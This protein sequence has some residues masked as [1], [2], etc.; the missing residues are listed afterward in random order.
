VLVTSSEVDAPDSVD[1]ENLLARL[2]ESNPELLARILVED[3]GTWR[4]SDE[5]KP[6]DLEAAKSIRK[7]VEHWLVGLGDLGPLLFPTREGSLPTSGA[8]FDG[9]MLTA[10]WHRDDTGLPAVIGLP[11]D[12]FRRPEWYG[13]RMAPW[14]PRPHWPW[15]W[16]LYDWARVL[17]SRAKNNAFPAV[18]E[19]AMTSEEDWALALAIAGQG[20]LHFDPVP[21]QLWE[22][23]LEGYGNAGAIGLW[24]SGFIPL[25]RARDFVRRLK[26][27]GTQSVE[28]PW[29][30]PDQFE[31]HRP[32]AQWW[33]EK[34]LAE[35]VRAV[36]SGGIRR[37][38]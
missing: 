20:S 30:G 37:D 13:Y 21:V 6:G 25:E 26:N 3:V 23:R 18:T 12:P 7:A 4:T 8:R 14:Q 34:R 2:A 33:S 19:G 5:A 35:R 9:E 27:K 29:P 28:A 32:I 36:Y 10:A 16:S 22:D 17:G 31:P 38:R 11:S 24:P 1:V 15:F